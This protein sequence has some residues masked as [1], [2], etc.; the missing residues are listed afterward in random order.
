[1][2][3]RYFYTMLYFITYTVQYKSV[4]IDITKFPYKICPY[5]AHS[6]NSQHLAWLDS[7]HLGRTFLPLEGAWVSFVSLSS[8]LV[9]FR[10]Y[11]YFWSCPKIRSGSCVI[12]FNWRFWT[13]YGHYTLLLLQSRF[14]RHPSVWELFFIFSRK[15]LGQ[16][17][18][19]H[20]Q[21]TV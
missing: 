17:F 11:P 4:S 7:I 2:V 10:P 8:A 9:S 18:F 14:G 5:L 15:F 21:D 12:N 1:M 20:W 3:D 13:Q 16:V 6:C 19:Y